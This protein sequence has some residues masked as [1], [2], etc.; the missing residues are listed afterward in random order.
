MR[1][2]MPANLKSA[3]IRNATKSDVSRLRDTEILDL[4]GNIDDSVRKMAALKCIRVLSRK[5]LQEVLD[6]HMNRVENQYY[7]VIHWLDFGVSVPR[8]RALTAAQKLLG[9][10]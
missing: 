8:E 9:R 5:R 2:E 1:L 7:N 10:Q 3:L 4:L 6:R